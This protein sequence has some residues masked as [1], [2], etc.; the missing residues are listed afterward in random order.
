MRTIFIGDKELKLNAKVLALTYY[1]QE[2][3]E[4][5]LDDFASIAGGAEELNKDMDFSKLRLTDVLKMAYALNKATVHP[6][7]PFPN[8][9]EWQY[10]LEIDLTN[11]GWYEGVIS[12]I[13]EGFFRSAGASGGAIQAAK[14]KAGETQKARSDATSEPQADGV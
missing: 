6:S 10:D 7:E 8:F 2:F 11:F 3:G 5:L 14:K 1:Q 13:S 4:S 9:L 12:E